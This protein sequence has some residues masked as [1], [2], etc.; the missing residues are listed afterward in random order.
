MRE[1]LGEL[2]IGGFFCSGE[3]GQIHART[4]LHGYTSSVALFRPRGWD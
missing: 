4:F 1:T 3:I 2:P